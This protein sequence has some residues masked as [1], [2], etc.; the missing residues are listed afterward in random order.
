MRC[1]ATPNPEWALHSRTA[2][3]PPQI[4]PESG[5]L[6]PGGSTEV[7]LSCVF[8]DLGSFS[9]DLFLREGNSSEDN[10]SKVRIGCTVIQQTFEVRYRLHLQL[11]MD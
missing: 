11:L 9:G 2:R 6:A 8:N 3:R 5:T 7:E 4:T 1:A 10:A